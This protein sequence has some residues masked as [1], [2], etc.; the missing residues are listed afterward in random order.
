MD[1]R[2]PVLRNPLISMW[3]CLVIIHLGVRRRCTCVDIPRL[4]CYFLESHS[5]I[6]GERL[7]FHR[8]ALGVRMVECVQHR[9]IVTVPTDGLDTTVERQ[10]A[11]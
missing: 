6:S 10:C 9:I 8:G 4:Q 1:G 5:N 7:V 2:C 11:R 3:D